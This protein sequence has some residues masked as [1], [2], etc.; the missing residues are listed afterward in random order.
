MKPNELRTGDCLRVIT[1]NGWRLRGEVVTI[2][3][4]YAVIRDPLTGRETT[5]SL[6]SIEILELIEAPQ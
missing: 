5:V 4:G 3:G 2:S 1:K 6:D